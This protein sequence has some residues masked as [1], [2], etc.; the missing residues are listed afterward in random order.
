[1]KK[2][3]AIYIIGGGPLGLNII[4]WAKEIGLKVIVTDRNPEA[5]GLKMAD[6]IMISDA[7]DTAKHLQFVD[8]IRTFY[9]IVGVYCQIEMG[10][11]ALYHIRNYLQ[12]DNNSF[13]SLENSLN[14][15]RMKETWIING[16]S[17][18]K[19]YQVEGH[20][21]LKN[22]L[23]NRNGNFIIKPSKGSGSRGV[24][25]LN[26]NS[27]FN[28][29]F[30][31]CMQSVDNEGVAILEEFVLGR[32]I[33][34]NGVLINGEFYPGGI[35]EKFQTGYPY[36]LP[37]GGYNPADI[38]KGDEDIVYNLL[39]DAATSIGLTDGPI[40]G[41]L[42][43]A[44]NGYEI[45]EVAPRFHG[46]VTTSNT[47]SSGTGINPVKFY[48]K[49]LYSGE[50]DCSFLKPK[51]ERCAIWRVICLPPGILKQQSKKTLNTDSDSQISMVWYNKKLKDKIG[52]YN[53]TSKIP[54]YICA[55]GENNVSAEKALEG[56]FES[57]KHDINIDDNCVEW[58]VRLGERLDAIGFSHKSCG[59]SDISNKKYGE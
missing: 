41:D 5:P 15:E 19:Y 35:L 6:R 45:L 38:S 2:Q 57:H 9:D 21:E 54:G 55:Y 8:K 14:K 24:Q 58:Y 47:L 59:Y 44:K 32:S 16:I 42:I 56:Y 50:I 1:M 36:F 3:R 17:T 43:K 18:P 7:T 53:D 29:I 52:I 4:K 34:V 46:D 31:Y 30:N 11:M 27:D 10:L 20:N 12:L 48:F 39:A 37:L 22:I 33:D 49:Y 40:K 25:I 13:D 28:E 23:K 51:K 26:K